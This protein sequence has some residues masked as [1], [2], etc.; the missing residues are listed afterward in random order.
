MG[1]VLSYFHTGP[2]FRISVRTGDRKGAGTDANVYI[3]LVD[4]EGKRSV[5]IH[6]DGFLQDD[7]E[8]GTVNTFRRWSGVEDFGS[9]SFIEIWRDSK[10]I[11][12]DWFCDVIDV[13]NV[14]SNERHI[15]PV[16]RWIPA[17][18][19]IK[20]RPFD[21]CL[22]QCDDL[23]DQRKEELAGTK[24]RYLLTKNMVIPQVKVFPQDQ[25]FSNDYMWDLGK[26]VIQLKLRAKLTEIMTG[27]WK[28]IE[29]IK[30][31]YRPPVLPIPAK[32]REWR[33]DKNF[34]RQRLQGCNP[35]QIRLCKELPKRFAISDE[36]LNPLLE[37]MKVEEALVMQKLFIV[38]YSFMKDLPCTDNRKVCAPTALFFLNEANDL[39]PVAIQLFPDPAP[40]NP[41]FY[42]TDPE[43]TW[44]LAKMYFNNA[45]TAVHESAV[46]LGFTHLVGEAIAVASHQCLSPS[47]PIFRLL[48]P[49][50][51]FLIA[52]NNMAVADLVSKGG[53]VDKTMVIGRIGM[54]E[55]IKRMWTD[56]RLDV[57]GSLIGDLEDRGVADPAVLPNYPY[58]DDAL[59]FHKPINDYARAIVEQYYDSAEKVQE[60]HE[61]QE[62]GRV[63]GS[64][65]RDPDE[66]TVNMKGLPN[67]GRFKTVDEVVEVVTNFIFIC[68]VGHASANFGQYDEYAF[69]PNYPAWLHGSPPRD[70]TPLTEQDIIAQLPDKAQTLSVITLTKILSSKGTNSLGDFEVQYIYEPEALKAV[71]RFR[72]ALEDV[73][74]IIDKRNAEREVKYLYLHPKDVPNAISI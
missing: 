38:D 40:D 30:K 37:N 33:S 39:M 58:R 64:V 62:W 5:D 14:L 41:V 54:L 16:H 72:D 61:L 63:L 59:L 9:L 73:G 6:L 36:D 44:L 21:M 34:G 3:A 46:H 71:E 28:T 52:I 26:S 66:V 19:K 8:K 70:K 69:P 67:G 53:W 48:A 17:D 12:D 25:S 11:F 60:D 35:G 31:I 49:H 22:P 47:H 13:T 56:W 45:D 32:Y 15:F 55:I 24:A 20:L 57:Q 74:E 29:D 51:L 1:V 23:C 7:F 18:K 2:Q 65:G 43:Y 10:G 68:S 27:R 4:S 50:F 42:P